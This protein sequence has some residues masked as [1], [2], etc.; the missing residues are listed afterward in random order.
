MNNYFS[1]KKNAIYYIAEI[2]GNHEGDVNYALRLA[3]LAADSGADAVKYQIYTGDTL[4]SEIES[5]DR[6]QHFKKFELNNEQYTELSKICSERDCDFM[7][8]I[9]DGDLI[10]Y[11]DPHIN[12][13]KIGSGDLTCYPILRVLVA[14]GKP[15][16]LSTGLSDMS[17]VADAVSYIEKLDSSYI[18]DNK[19]ALLQCTSSYPTPDHDANINAMLAL[20]EEFGLPVGYSDHTIGSD[21]L[22]AAVAL[23]AEIIEK[24]FTDDRENKTFRDHKVSLTCDETRN[25]LEK[26]KKIKKLL[27]SRSKCLTKSE[28]ESQH[29]ISFRRSIYAARDI[30]KGD[31]INAQNI[32]CLR[33]A[34]GI[35]AAKYDDVIGMTLNR[36]IR[37]HEV[38]REEDLI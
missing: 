24:H 16:I 28:K 12:I 11:F 14:T 35:S 21:A 29:H 2:G 6:N 10:K 37:R 23:G 4:V 31:K 33:P 30:V 26:A 34:H 7:A 19:L 36:N 9:W 32:T 25:F 5:P 38:I 15:I 27:G 22:E 20:R 3:Q 1:S 8:S 17:E 13:H 18:S